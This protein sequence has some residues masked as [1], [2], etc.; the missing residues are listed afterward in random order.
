MTWSSLW[1]INMNLSAG[2]LFLDGRKVS[3]SNNNKLSIHIMFRV[4]CF[5]KSVHTKEEESRN[6][7]RPWFRISAYSFFSRYDKL[8]LRVLLNAVGRIAT[9]FQLKSAANLLAAD[10][11]TRALTSSWSRKPSSKG[12]SCP[13]S[14]NR[15]FPVLEKKEM[16][17]SSFQIRID[18]VVQS[19]CFYV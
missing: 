9:T 5:R 7:P 8:V 10:T 19:V 1:F 18:I 14:T 13:L 6:C 2:S 4:V 15:K 12:I 11:F 17:P 16:R 3:V